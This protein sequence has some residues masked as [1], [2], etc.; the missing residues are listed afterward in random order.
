MARR[1]REK[2]VGLLRLYRCKTPPYNCQKIIKDTKRGGLKKLKSRKRGRGDRKGRR[3]NGD[4][5][6]GQIEM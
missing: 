6:R 1:A 2:D 5:D 3:K 4:I